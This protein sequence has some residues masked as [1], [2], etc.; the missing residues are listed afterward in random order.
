M[1]LY[2]FDYTF[3]KTDP[4]EEFERVFNINLY[5]YQ[6]IKMVIASST[7]HFI[8]VDIGGIVDHH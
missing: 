3:K 2:Q 1:L 6:A 4:S 8:P 7:A 5:L